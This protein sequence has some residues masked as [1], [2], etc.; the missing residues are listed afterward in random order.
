MPRFDISFTCRLLL[1]ISNVSI[2]IFAMRWITLSGIQRHHTQVHISTHRHTPY[3]LS[4]DDKGIL[5]A[6]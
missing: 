6:G 5:C 3:Y 4:I 2:D 1:H